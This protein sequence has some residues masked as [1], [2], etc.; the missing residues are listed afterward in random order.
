[1]TWRD[2]L[3][4]H[5]VQAIADRDH[6]RGAHWRP[7]VRLISASCRWDRAE[8][9]CLWADL[10]PARVRTFRT[11]IP[12]M[13]I[14]PSA[15]KHGIADEDIEHAT[16]NAMTIDDLDDLQMYL[17]PARNAGLLRDRHRGS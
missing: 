7:I 1:L 13:E 8:G 17:G 4:D 2:D 15:R 9:S 3:A 11:T 10:C 6:P 14:H 5:A 12:D 16:R